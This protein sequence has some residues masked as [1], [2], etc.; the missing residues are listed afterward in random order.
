MY[1][2]SNMRDPNETTEE[3]AAAK[4][5]R[6]FLPVIERVLTESDIRTPTDET[7]SPDEKAEAPPAEGPAE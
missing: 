7:S 5:G 2:S 3:S 6:E 1:F 4:F